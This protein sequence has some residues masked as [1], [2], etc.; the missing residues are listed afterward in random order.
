MH[1]SDRTLDMVKQMMRARQREAEI[2]AMRPRHS[3][4]GLMA[5]FLRTLADRIDP[6]GQE[7]EEVSFPS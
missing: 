1:D 5:N 7:R 4:S 6:T 2:E 3:R